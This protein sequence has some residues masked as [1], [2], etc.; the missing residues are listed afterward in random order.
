MLNFVKKQEGF[1]LIELMIAIVIVAILA[2][3]A[4]P[5]Y[6]NSVQNS[7]RT[8][9]TSM[10][11]QAAALQE[12]AYFT[13]NQ[14]NSDIATLFGEAT[15]TTIESPENYYVITVATGTAA[16]AN[17]AA[18]GNCFLL[19]ATAQGTQA[20]D[21]DCNVFTLHSNGTQ[22]AQDDG[23]ADNPNCWPNN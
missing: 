1:S 22:N 10:L 23:G 15:G 9:A 7:R 8:D 6:L 21:T 17:C 14:Y 11:T 5:S 2:G 12:R 3:V 16:P 19:T 20:D 4:L 13:T 18:I